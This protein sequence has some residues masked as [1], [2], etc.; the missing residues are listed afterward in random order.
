[1]TGSPDHPDWDLLPGNPAAFFGLSLPV[2]R[3]A[4]R[5]RYVAFIRVHKPEKDPEAF[6]RIRAAY[7]ALCRHPDLEDGM[8]SPADPGEHDTGGADGVGFRDR[9]EPVPVWEE[10][11][12]RIRDELSRRLSTAS[13][14]EIYR[15]LQQRDDLE[16]FHYVAL[17]ALADVE[18]PDQPAAFTRWVIEGLRRFPEAPGLEALFDALAHRPMPGPHAVEVLRMA[19]DR[20]PGPQFC[21]WTEPIWVRLAGTMPFRVWHSLYDELVA[22]ATDLN[23]DDRQVLL[24]RALRPLLFTAN[25][26]WLDEQIHGLA[27]ADSSCVLGTS[28]LWT[29]STS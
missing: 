13:T 9:M 5:R 15:D 19:R 6:Q 21:T 26:V 3:S 14:G 7:E 2:D 20:L 24:F 27:G 16:W 23:I 1:M 11:R 10:P 28:G 4:L 18:E 12:T 25:P 17:A 29:L 22:H 8:P